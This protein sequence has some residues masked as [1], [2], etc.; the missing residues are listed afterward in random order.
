[1]SRDTVLLIFACVSGLSA[2]IYLQLSWIGA[3]RD[4]RRTVLNDAFSKAMQELADGVRQ[5]AL[6]MLLLFRTSTALDVMDS[7]G[8][9]VE[10]HEF[11]AEDAAWAPALKRTLLF[12]LPAEAGAPTGLRVLETETGTLRTAEWPRDLLGLEP[13]LLTFWSRYGDTANP[14][15]FATWMVYPDHS[16]IARPLMLSPS[17]PGGLPR[18]RG[19]LIL[20]VDFEY[21][22][23]KIVMNR[24]RRDRSGLDEQI[25]YEVALIW[26]REVVQVFRPIAT[27]NASALAGGGRQ[28]MWQYEI[29]PRRSMAEVS[30]LEDADWRQA[31]VLP[32]GYVSPTAVSKGAT[33]RAWLAPFAGTYRP[34]GDPA[35]LV[36]FAPGRSGARIPLRPR[37]YLSSERQHRLE[38]ASHRLSGA[39]DDAVAQQYWWNAITSLGVLALLGIAIAL[40]ATG[41]RRAS[42]LAEMRMAFVANVSHELRTPVASMRVIGQNIADGLVGSDRRLLRYG[43]LVRDQ[44]KRLGQMIEDTLLL[45][46]I[47]SGEKPL[48]LQSV[49][50]GPVIREA[51]AH[52]RPLIE[53]TGFDLECVIPEGLAN[54][55]ADSNALRQS[56]SN[57][58]TNAVKHASEGRWLKVEAGGDAGEHP[59]HVEIRVHDRGP[60]I[61]PTDARR[62]FEP[63]YRSGR[64]IRGAVPG[65]GMGLS[66][67]SDLVRMMGGRLALQSDPGRGSVFTIRLPVARRER[68][69]NA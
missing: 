34:P 27:A 55:Q 59:G 10:L 42:R 4:S 37:I 11:W 36:Q 49:A 22:A 2:L 18:V 33:Q 21:L 43:E 12:D 25:P 56:L 14:R 38:L 60:G 26:G 41:A 5:D 61:D 16:V 28:G 23:E 64:A 39:V 6:Q 53:R 62:V 20:Q 51:I 44:A 45:A 57:L 40:V 3:A 24:L 19:H 15:W 8:A 50:V 67:A 48:D 13:K 63:Y 69:E 66:L 54:V 35:E 31:L 30:W 65:S 32:D 29:G 46:R 9:A 17:R 68:P 52:V 58:L 7:A 1:M 47:E